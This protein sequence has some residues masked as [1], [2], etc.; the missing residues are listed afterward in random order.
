MIF[1]YNEIDRATTYLKKLFERKRSVKIEL[2]TQ[3]KTIS[4]LGY[5]W[6]CFTHIGFETGNN[7]DDIYQFC[8]QKFP[9]HKSI[10]IN[11]EITLIPVTLS[12]MDKEITSTFIDQFV[13]FFSQEGF[14][15]PDP[16]D[17]KCLEMFQ[18]YKERGML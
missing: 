4:Q 13:T 9:V 16:E 15:V 7:K 17:K 10:E 12:G 2:V 5:C 1:K 8:L 14:D 18:Y 6:L 3:S 11:G